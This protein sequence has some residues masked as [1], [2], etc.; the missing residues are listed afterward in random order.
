DAAPPLLPPRGDP[1]RRRDSCGVADGKRR[2]VR[3]RA[4]DW[5]VTFGG[6]GERGGGGAFG[7]GPCPRRW[8][9]TAVAP[10]WWQGPPRPPP[11][12]PR[13]RPPPPRRRPRLP[14]R[15]PPVRSPFAGHPLQARAAVD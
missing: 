13:P 10:R 15:R 9:C 11:A 7:R 5:C 8:F 12:P 1:S 2:G 14:A 6:S 4:R 3:V